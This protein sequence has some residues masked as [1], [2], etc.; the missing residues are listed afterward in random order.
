MN[1]K[2]R[3]VYYKGSI[4]KDY[5]IKVEEGIIKEIL[6]NSEISD[7]SSTISVDGFIY[8]AFIESHAH[9]GEIANALAHVSGENLS[10]TDILKEVEKNET[11]FIFNVN[12]NH[13][14]REQFKHL[15]N[16]D[17][18][19]FMQSKDEH[20]VFV[21][22]KL[23]KSHSID[24][25]TIDR[26]SLTFLNDEFIGIFKDSAINFVKHIKNI[27]IDDEV[28]SKVDEYF[29]SRGIVTVMN[30]DFY[31]KDHLKG[32]KIRIVQGIAK[33]YLDDAIK[34]GIKTGI[35]SDNSTY[36][37]LKVFLD[38]SL[39][40]QTAKMLNDTPFAGLLLMDEAEFEEI[41]RK[42]NANGINVAVHAIGSEAVHVALN[43]FNKLKNLSVMNR[44]EHIQFIDK[45]DL[46]LL[47][48]APF[49]PSMQ[50]IH[51]KSDVELYKKYMDGYRYAYAFNSVYK[52]KGV[53]VFGSDAPVED[54]SVFKGLESA[55]RHP[56]FKEE[57]IPLEVALKAYTEFAGPYNYIPKR[58]IIENQY[59]A[60]FIILKKEISLDNLL[61][62]E[63]L[64]VFKGG[65]IVWTK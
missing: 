14:T 61:D 7:V 10:F 20:S 32:R 13:I 50:P 4:L 28:L 26:K 53:L 24:Y 52:A 59:I 15:F 6:P 40:S 48:E 58:G 25:H 47:K 23:L 42:A 30:F 35:S 36:G 57:S 12:F 19:I 11:S 64:A 43:V 27:R 54:A 46:P 37:P 17:R 21:S 49:I 5:G 22:K 60:D 18:N 63:I 16:L 9:V 41:V 8:P 38:G 31:A 33:D 62:N 29:L 56:L 45:E 44:I 1:V 2:G 39:G 65:E 34:E 55:V 3:G 51:A